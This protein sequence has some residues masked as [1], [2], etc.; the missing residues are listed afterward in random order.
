MVQKFWWG[1]QF[2]CLGAGC[3]SKKVVLFNV[4]VYSVA[5]FVEA[6][7]CARELG[8]RYRGGFFETDQ[9]YCD[10]LVDGAF[11]KVLQIDLVRD[12]ESEL[13]VQAFDDALGPRL[14]LMGESKSLQQ[15]KDFFMGKK[16]ENGTAIY[17][18]QRTEVGGSSGT[19][20]YY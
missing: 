7:K 13:F 14:R 3:R 17:L 12:V 18:M 8:I 5:L 11:N 16:L 19:Q 10:A 9:D 2:R 6:E 15:F 4:N 20:L 1:D